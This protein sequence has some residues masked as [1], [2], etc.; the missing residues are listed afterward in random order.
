MRYA[1]FVSGTITVACTDAAKPDQTRV[2]VT[3][4][5]TSLSREGAVFVKKSRRRTTSSSK[6]GAN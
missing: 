3:Y 6:T 5:V 4:D 2:S 1:R